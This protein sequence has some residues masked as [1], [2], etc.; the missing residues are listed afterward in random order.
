M[1]VKQHIPLIDPY[2]NN[3][4]Y[5]GNYYEAFRRDNCR[6]VLCGSTENL[7]IHHIDGYNENV[8]ERSSLNRLLTLCRSCHIRV[9]RCG[10]QI[11]DDILSGIGHTAGGQ[12]D[13][14]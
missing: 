6:C 9:H 13:V 4:R 1:S 7:C 5:G 8:P 2:T 12:V 10:L 11:P 3:T 14:S